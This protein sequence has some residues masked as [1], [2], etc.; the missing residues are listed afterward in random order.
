MA[1]PDKVEGLQETIA[2]LRTKCRACGTWHPTIQECPEYKRK[3]DEV[4]TTLSALLNLVYDS[5][6]EEM[7][8]QARVDIYN[9]TTGY[10][11]I[12]FGAYV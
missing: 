9:Y 2:K 3:I 5:F 11:G 4:K 1:G 7:I 12:K 8:D 10:L 6:P